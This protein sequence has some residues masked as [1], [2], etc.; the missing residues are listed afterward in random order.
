MALDALVYSTG[1]DGEFDAAARQAR[2]AQAIAEQLG[3]PYHV[4]IALLRQTAVDP[5][6]EP[7]E[8]R[9]LAE[10]AEPM[11]RR[12]GSIH[13][14]ADLMTHVVMSAIDHQHYDTAEQLA[15]DGLRA[16]EEAGDLFAIQAALG[17]AGLAALFLERT[18]GAEQHF[19]DQLAICRR[20]RLKFRWA[21][22][23]LGLA[24][25]ATTAGDHERTAMLVGACD[26]TIRQSVAAADRPIFERLIDRFITPARVA[27]GDA[28]W[29][30]AH[31]A[32]AALSR[33]QM[34][35]LALEDRRRITRSAT[36]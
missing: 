31:A 12:C 8:V 15:G 20:E 11:L 9:A 4:A 19:R 16:A 5:R 28:E 1:F 6:L 30:R 21:E 29:A 17:N 10:Q 35:D 34:Y 7:H 23:A 36:A 22:P 25:V 26:A 13:R 2:E 27:L 3:D 24:I 14:L 32:G 18:G 33:E